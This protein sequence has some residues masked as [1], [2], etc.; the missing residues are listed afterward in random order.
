VPKSLSSSHRAQ[1]QGSSSQ[2]SSSSQRPDRVIFFSLGESE[3]ENFVSLLIVIHY[4]V[5]RVLDDRPRQYF[6][7]QFTSRNPDKLKKF[8]NA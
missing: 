7:E 6:F 5:L 4:L 8:P 1:E 3:G 2:N